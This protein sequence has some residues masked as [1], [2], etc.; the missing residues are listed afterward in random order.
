M[1]ATILFV[2]FLFMSLLV[3]FTTLIL[4]L[5]NGILPNTW[6]GRLFLLVMVS[7]FLG[8]LIWFASFVAQF[9]EL[10]LGAAMM[11][12]TF[13][14]FV[15]IL[16]L[17]N[18]LKVEILQGGFYQRDW[19]L[20]NYHSNE[21]ELKLMVRSGQIEEVLSH[22][23]EDY[24]YLKDHE[25]FQSIYGLERKYQNSKNKLRMKE[26]SHEEYYF[27]EKQIEDNLVKFINQ[28]A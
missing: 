11:V 12:T 18:G 21:Q 28:K 9:F 7:W 10:T 17:W 13:S 25:S 14:C 27:I 16:F 1:E 5:S 23:K 24:R 20:P 2:P 4:R 3:S 26:L 19:Y 6:F 22:L 8:S 15:T